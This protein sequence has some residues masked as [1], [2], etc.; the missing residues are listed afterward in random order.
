MKRSHVNTLLL[1]A[2][3]GINVY[4]IVLPVLPSVAFWLATRDT[5][6]TVRLEQKIAAASAADTALPPRDNRLIIPS[7]LLDETIHSGATARTLRDGLWIR[8]QAS[9]P[10]KAGNTVIVGHRFT[11]TN[12]RG[13]LY[14]LDKVRLGDSI[15]VWWEGTQHIYTVREIKTVKSHETHIEAPTDDSRLT[16][17]TC[18]PLWL[19]KD[20]LVVIATEDTL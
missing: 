8:P 9:T 18:T 10:D 11:Y 13:T 12:P 17:Y 19:P 2:V 4:I 6:K 1:I 15:A 16:L 3:L 20:R 7:M 5:S 14:H